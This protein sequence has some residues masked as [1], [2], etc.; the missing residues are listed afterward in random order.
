MRNVLL[1]AFF[2]LFSSASFAQSMTPYG[3]VE[4]KPDGYGVQ[5]FKCHGRTFYSDKPL[6]NIHGCDVDITSFGPQGR[7]SEVV[8]VHFD[9]EEG[10]HGGKRPRKEVF[11]R[12]PDGQMYRLTDTIFLESELL[13][14]AFEDIVTPLPGSL[15]IKTNIDLER[16]AERNI[17]QYS[18]IFCVNYYLKH[19]FGG[20]IG[21]CQG[22][23]LVGSDA[24][25]L[26][27]VMSF[28]DAAIRAQNLVYDKGLKLKGRLLGGNTMTAFNVDPKG[29]SYY[30]FAVPG[31]EQEGRTPAY[32][33]RVYFNGYVEMREES[34]MP[35]TPEE[36]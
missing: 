4:I 9:W 23:K 34:S 16:F 15:G 36:L 33:F 30:A 21:W 8:T 32:V 1:V 26:K 12:L 22:D 3:N 7:R 17:D 31:M 2:C 28:G 24:Y 6:P 11:Y 14:K 13:T 25:Y 19:P 20:T 29:W 27:G 10:A 35:E 5:T 18:G